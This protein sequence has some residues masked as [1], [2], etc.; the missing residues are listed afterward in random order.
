MTT[1]DSL[2]FFLRLIK[3]KHELLRERGDSLLR[4]LAGEDPSTKKSAA[5]AMLQAANDLRAV[6]SNGD[7]PPWLSVALIQLPHFLE[8]RCNSFDLLN[9]FIPLKSSLEKHRWVFDESAEIPFDFDSIF[10]HF[11]KESRLPELFD[12]IVRLLEEI[13]GSGAVDSLTMLRAL[14]KVISTFKRCKD[15]SYFSLNSAWEFLLS[16]LN[17]YLWGE[18]SKLPILGT[19]LEALGNTIRETNDEMYRLHTQVRDEMTRV[20]EEE[21]KVLADKSIFPFVAYDKNGHLLQSPTTRQL[22]DATA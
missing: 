8:G 9:N 2:Q 15:G 5:G 20:V 10:D 17:N 19:A 21:V 16:F 18:L 22:P 11:K 1:N 6:L 13:Q 14:G 4:A 3:Q 12:E 7:I